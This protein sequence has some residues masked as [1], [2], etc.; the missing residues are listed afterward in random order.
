[1]TSPM[2][3]SANICSPL[4]S[5][6]ATYGEDIDEYVVAVKKGSVGAYWCPN[7]CG[8][9][10]TFSGCWDRYCKDRHPEIWIRAQRRLIDKLDSD[11]RWEIDED[12]KGMAAVQCETL[13]DVEKHV[14]SKYVSSYLPIGATIPD[15]DDDEEWARMMAICR[16]QL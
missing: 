13:E 7:G 6:S 1:M 10:T 12:Y 2:K 16:R 9:N 4:A 15:I 8:W 11:D 3:P 5:G 14:E